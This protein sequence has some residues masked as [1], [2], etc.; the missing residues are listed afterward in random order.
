[1][2]ATGVPKVIKGGFDAGQVPRG[3]FLD[4]LGPTVLEGQGQQV[5][6]IWRFLLDA[7]GS[8]GD[9]R[10]GIAIVV[11]LFFNFGWGRALRFL[12]G[13]E[14]AV[15]RRNTRCCRASPGCPVLAS[16]ARLA[17]PSVTADGW[18]NQRLIPV[19][20]VFGVVAGSIHFQVDPG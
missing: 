17:N 8:S 10:I 14:F 1:M 11:V 4:L 19:F 20:V 12:H 3:Q 5:R 18:H 13:A 2:I 16:S 9:A 6:V 7:G 15:G